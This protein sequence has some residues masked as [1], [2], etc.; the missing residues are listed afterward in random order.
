MRKFI[1]AFLI[2]GIFYFSVSLLSCRAAEP[3]A[4]ELL[5][6]G[7]AVVTRYTGRAS[8]VEIP[9]ELGGV[10]VR[11]IGEEAFLGCERITRITIPEGAVRIG[12]YAFEYC[13]SLTSVTIPQSVREIGYGAFKNCV[14]LKEITLPETLSLLESCVFENCASL[15]RVVF[16]ETAKEV[17][18]GTFKNCTSLREAVPA[19]SY[20]R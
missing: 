9:A 6:D 16:P 2:C 15:E 11:E 4:Y 8:V 3:F 5:E 14:S 19:D 20:N 1:Y 7:T 12:R 18:P 17:P 10:P 13:T